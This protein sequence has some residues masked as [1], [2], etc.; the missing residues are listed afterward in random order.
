MRRRIDDASYTIRFTPRRAR[1]TWSAVNLRRVEEL[2][3]L[4]RMTPAGLAAHEAR[5]AGNSR[6]YSYERRDTQLDPE[7]LRRLQADPEA[8][9]YFSAQPPWYRRTASHWVVSAKREETR[10]RRLARLIEA[11]AAGRRID[12]A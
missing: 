9:A 7:R 1:S 10:D 5:Q 12:R 3:A 8:W 6:I 11:C 2:V 4:G